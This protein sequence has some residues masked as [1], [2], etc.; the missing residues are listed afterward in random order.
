MKSKLLILK[1]FEFKKRK[2]ITVVLKV[3]VLK[4]GDPS[5]LKRIAIAIIL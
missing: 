4:F 5:T 2:V 1:T 3:R